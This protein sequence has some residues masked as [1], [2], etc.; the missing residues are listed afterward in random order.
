MRTIIDKNHRTIAFL[1]LETH[2]ET[3]VDAF[4]VDRRAQGKS[5]GTLGFYRQKLALFGE[6]CDA[7]GVTT[8]T[9][10]NPTLIRNFILW[11]QQRGHNKG[12]V[13]AFYRVLRAF[14]YWWEEEYEP[15]R[16][17]KL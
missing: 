15:E 5:E 3:Q 8:T 16:L 6:Y 2:I 1:E 10:L 7:Q 14:L 4:L 9:Q 12:G 13:H 11:L 17:E